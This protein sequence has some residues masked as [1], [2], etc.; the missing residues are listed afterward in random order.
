MKRRMWPLRT[1]GAV[2]VASVL[3]VFLAAALA[4]CGAATKASRSLAGSKTL[5]S[6]IGG[7]PQ[8][9]TGDFDWIQ[10]KNGEWLK[11]EIKDLQD[12]SF[13]FESDELD[14][15]QLDWE[16]IHAVYSA[17]EHTCV[18]EDRTSV[19]G[20][21]RIEGDRVIVVTTPEG[22]KRYDRADLRFII[23]GGQTEWDYWSLEYTLGATVR[24]GNSDQSD[25]SSFLRIR[26][27]SPTARTG[28]E[29]RAA[30]GSVEGKETVNNQLAD[31]RHDV[32]LSRRLYLTAPTV[33]YYRDRPQNIAYQMTP[34]AGLG[35]EI[36][37]RGH[38]EW[39]AGGGAGYQH[40]EFDEVAPGQDSS[41]GGGVILGL[42]DFKWELTKNV[43]FEFQYNTT[44]GLAENLG[45]NH[46]VF[47]TLSFDI[48]KNFDFD[49]SLTWNRVGD[50]QRTSDGD[51]PNEDDISLYV[52]LGWEF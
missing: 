21:L 41:A 39:T 5:T 49:V 50:A 10:F 4:G 35:Y 1:V 36:I 24:Q 17:T 44:V 6:D 11:G 9:G 15:L 32:F 23:P 48:W 3:L 45:V 25:M 2:A 51:K 19:L 16:D 52:G 7:P 31:L 42:T 30:F 40:T 26:R 47:T 13:S 43:D 14:T 33:H 28:F 38:M 29:Y 46:H 27:R 34:G 12:D 22:E 37:D 18:F 8:P 20:K